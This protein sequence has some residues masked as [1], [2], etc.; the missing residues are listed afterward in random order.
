M[1]PFLSI[2]PS[3]L[4]SL[5]LSRSFVTTIPFNPIAL[6][7]HLVLR[8]LSSPLCDAI[9]LFSGIFKRSLHECESSAPSTRFDAVWTILVTRISVS[10]S[11]SVITFPS[12][13]DS[14]REPRTFLHISPYCIIPARIPCL[15]SSRATSADEF[16]FSTDYSAGTSLNAWTS[17]R[18]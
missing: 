18:A 12:S 17:E 9:S 15:I 2:P 11:T 3:I 10:T 1:L 13:F 16:E 4:R 6:H 7:A 14:R 5:S 8:R